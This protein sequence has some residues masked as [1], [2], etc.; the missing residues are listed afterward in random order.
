MLDSSIM[1]NVSQPK[2]CQTDSSIME[3]VNQ[4]KHYQSR[5]GQSVMDVIEDFDLQ[6]NFYIANALKYLLRCGKK[7][8]NPEKQE[9]LKAIWYLNRYIEYMDKETTYAQI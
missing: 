7:D 4:P 9:I 2:H 1:E 8:N 6:Y 3:N 5:S